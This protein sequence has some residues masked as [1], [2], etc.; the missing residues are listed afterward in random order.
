M[1]RNATAFIV[2]KI[3]PDTKP[4]AIKLVIGEELTVRGFEHNCPCGC[5]SLSYMGIDRRFNTEQATWKV[6]SGSFHDIAMLTLSP[7][8]GIGRSQG[9]NG[10]FHW[11]GFLE[12]GV[13]VEK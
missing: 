7:S 5:G 9:L 6:E 8:I 2:D 3:T 10:G 12:N 4:G 11:H 1:A 13:F